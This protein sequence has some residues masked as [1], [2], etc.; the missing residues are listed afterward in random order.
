MAN[1]LKFNRAD[2]TSM[3]DPT[4][5]SGDIFLFPEAMGQA[6]HPFVFLVE[7]PPNKTRERHYH[8]GDVVYVYVKGEHHIEGEGTYRAGDLRW[9]KAGHAYGP[10]TTGPDGGAWWV[11]SYADP[12]PVNVPAN[13]EPAATKKGAA[14]ASSATPSQVHADAASLP[15]FQ[16]PYDWAAI[17][18]AVFDAGGVI[19]D[20]LL[21][22]AEVDRFNAD[23]DR[24]LEKSDNKGKPNSGA[25]LYDTFLGHRT[26]R[27]HGLIEKFES[28][29]ELI[30]QNELVDWTKRMLSKRA[31]SVLLSAGEFIQIGPGEPAQ[32]LHRDVD[33]WL[34]API[35]EWPL[36][37][38]AIIAF[39]DFT[40]DN[41]ATYVV[42]HSWDWDLK[43]QPKR[44]EIARAV[45]KAGDVVLFR[46][47]LL[48]GGGE[49]VSEGRRRGVSLTYCAGWLRPV[50]NSF[51]NIS[52]DTAQRMP[53]QVQELLGYAMHN[54]THQR[55]GLLGLYENGDPARALAG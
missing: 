1:A 46:G 25:T 3:I 24:F 5:G 8:H 52:R 38:N 53:K 50:E 22:K 28:A 4:T 11:I 31:N 36:L 33:A 14:K 54:L 35:N 29:A 17:D 12:I 51:L 43:R 10:E 30:G 41:G 7:D 47:D 2:T 32:F 37:V 48:H 16:R 40:L 19:L 13:A 18:K 44:E 42:P 34:D 21:S 45:M 20:G 27:F 39:D 49:N 26:V 15:H 55:G 23:M 6:G 9:T